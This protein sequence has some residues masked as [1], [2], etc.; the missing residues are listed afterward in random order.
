MTS[1]RQKSFINI[2]LYGFFIL[3]AGFGYLQTNGFPQPLL[4]GYPG[5]AMFPRLALTLMGVFAAAGIALELLRLSR[6]AAAEPQAPVPL[7]PDE[8]AEEPTSARDFLI[9]LAMLASFVAVMQWVG[10]EVGVLLFVAAMVYFV[11]RRALTSILSGVAAVAVVYVIFC[12]LLS[13]FMP[14]TFLPRYLNW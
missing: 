3:V 7:A 2:G 10:M 9:V 11:T 1:S 14:L 12:Q 6:S 4:P 8:D 13:V 5:S